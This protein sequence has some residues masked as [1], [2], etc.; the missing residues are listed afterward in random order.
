MEE[1]LLEG[2]YPK[3]LFMPGP[4]DR[5]GIPLLLQWETVPEH[6]FGITLEND[7][8]GVAEKFRVA[9]GLEHLSFRVN[10]RYNKIIGL[11]QNLQFPERVRFL[12]SNENE[13]DM[14]FWDPDTG[15]FTGKNIAV[16][17]QNAIKAEEKRKQDLFLGERVVPPAAA[18]VSDPKPVNLFLSTGSEDWPRVNDVIG[19]MG[20]NKIVLVTTGAMNP[21]HNSHVQMM[22]K[23]R[24]YLVRA[25]Y[26]VLHG[27]ISPSSDA[28][29]STK[30]SPH[31][32]AATRIAMVRA[33][34]R[35]L[36]PETFLS[37]GQWES[38]QQGFVD[39]PDVVHNL[40][41]HLKGI[42]VIYVCGADHARYIDKSQFNP[43]LEGVAIVGRIQGQ[44]DAV[45][46][47][48]FVEHRQRNIF[49]VEDDSVTADNAT[50]I[51]DRIRRGLSIEGMVSPG[52]AQIAIQN[53]SQ[54]LPRK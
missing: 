45:V 15:N 18:A 38:K 4:P 44:E 25:G 28:Y 29:L 7:K 34:I 11:R 1:W 50:S 54:I 40:S 20:T 8:T 42:R 43:S 26:N 39:F 19:A 47:H 31:Y 22:F 13:T 41:R 30:G 49:V 16:G 46:K 3:N 17:V 48:G 51:R 35:D 33:T 37:V 12:V 14:S 24:E 6:K 53:K 23:T 5:N 21:I 2:G 27:W 36:L 52:V 10:D 9:T 32:D